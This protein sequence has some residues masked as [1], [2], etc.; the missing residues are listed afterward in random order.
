[1]NVTRS[2]PVDGDAPDLMDVPTI[3]PIS[4]DDLVDGPQ[5]FLCRLT[6][7]TNPDPDLPIPD[8]LRSLPAVELIPI[9]TPLDTVKSPS[10]APIP[11]AAMKF[12]ATGV[13]IL[14]TSKGTVVCSWQDYRLLVNL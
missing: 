9:P 4:E 5:R 2:W 1:M 3:V 14:A 7:L 10:I 11:S 8:R 12:T 13:S 6:A